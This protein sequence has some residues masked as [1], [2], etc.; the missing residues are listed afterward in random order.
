MVRQQSDELSEAMH[1]FEDFENASEP[2]EKI[3][4]FEAG[5]E[6]LNAYVRNHPGLSNF[7]PNE[8]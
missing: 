2:G 1:L 3:R 7:L 8:R 4:K 5:V 6:R